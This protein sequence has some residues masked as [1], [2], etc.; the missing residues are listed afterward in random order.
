M[1]KI[2]GKVENAAHAT[3][4]SFPRIT[5]GTCGVSSCP[6]FIQYNSIWQQKNMGILM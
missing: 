6:H 4:T 2:G 1:E 3:A 5:A